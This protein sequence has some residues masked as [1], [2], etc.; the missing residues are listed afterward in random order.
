MGSYMYQ[1]IDNIE[2]G[3]ALHSIL[4]CMAGLGRKSCR[5]AIFLAG[6]S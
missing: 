4:R 1:R 3:A 5:K 6:L 2:D